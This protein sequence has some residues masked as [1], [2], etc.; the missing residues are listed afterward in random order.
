MPFVCLSL[1]ILG[2]FYYSFLSMSLLFFLDVSETGFPP[3]LHFLFNV[4]MVLSHLFHPLLNLTVL[5]SLF[6]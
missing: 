1:I 4:S 5:N 6:S 3:P 2:Q